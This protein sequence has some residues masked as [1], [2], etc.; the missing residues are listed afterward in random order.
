MWHITV[1]F[2]SFC[3]S[4][5]DVVALKNIEALDRG[6]E[7]VS[8]DVEVIVMEQHSEALQFWPVGARRSR[9]SLDAW[10]EPV[11]LVHVDSHSDLFEIEVDEAWFSLLHRAE[12]TFDDPAVARALRTEWRAEVAPM[13][14]IS[15]FVTAA[16]WLGFV[17]SVVWVRSDFPGF[18][19]YNGPPPGRYRANLEWDRNWR[20]QGRICIRVSDTVQRFEDSDLRG[21]NRV[22]SFD[23]CGQSAASAVPFELTVITLEYALNLIKHDSAESLLH[24]DGDREWILDVDLDVFATYDPPFGL[25][26]D[27]NFSEVWTRQLAFHLDT[28]RAC[29]SPPM[30]EPNWTS[31][32]EVRASSGCG[33]FFSEDDMEDLKLN[34][35]RDVGKLPR[36]VTAKTSLT[37]VVHD[38]AAVVQGVF[39]E[40]CA[41]GEASAMKVHELLET[42]SL[43][44]VEAWEQVFDIAHDEVII[45]DFSLSFFEGASGIHHASWA[46]A[47]RHM[48]FF[49]EL[50]G[51]FGR[52]LSAPTVVTLCRSMEPDRYLPRHLWPEVET[53]ALRLI[54]SFLNTAHVRIKYLDGLEPA[55]SDQERVWNRDEL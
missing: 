12:E 32:G 35:V 23:S 46:E 43:P 50:L 45:E 52:G 47:K 34:L 41:L 49:K 33:C 11:T 42:M 26:L 37:T 18:G 38:K 4:T 9:A 48:Q 25:F 8:D 13:V 30:V 6:V 21:T 54:H 39:P 51:E 55:P 28:N 36:Q 24:P 20:T 1:P 5:F 16:L 2:V 27:A 44:E 17:D 19:A 15:T 14:E 40:G 10:A 31:R 22:E 29:S 3:A 7:D 53:N